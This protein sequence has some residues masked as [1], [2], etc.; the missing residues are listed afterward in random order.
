MTCR[1]EDCNAC[2]ECRAELGRVVAQDAELLRTRA[3]MAELQMVLAEVQKALDASEA[4]L[5]RYRGLYEKSRPNCSEHVSREEQQLVFESLLAAAN[6]TSKDG[7]SGANSASTSDEPASSGVTGAPTGSGASPPAPGGNGRPKGKGRP[8]GRRRLDLTHLPVDSVVFD[9]EE[10]RAAGGIGYT[11]VGSERS[12]RLAFVASRYVRL[13]IVR[14]TYRRDEPTSDDTGPE[15]TSQLPKSDDRAEQ[16]DSDEPVPDATLVTAPIPD[17]VWPNIMA[18]PST[19]AHT[20][21]AKYDD[22][23]PLNR[24]EGISHREGFTIHRS[25]LCGWL[26]SAHQVVTGIVDSM[27]VEGKATAHCMATDAT[28]ASVRPK[29]KGPCENWHIFV[30]IADQDHVVFR[31]AR[32]HDSNVLKGMLLGY[33]G[34]LLGDATSIYSPLI[35]VGMVVVAYCWAH[36]RRYF[37]RAIE[38]DRTRAH[39]AIAIIGQLFAVQR[40]CA[41]I[42]MPERTEQR[43]KLAE[44]ILQ[45]FDAWVDKHRDAVDPRSPLEAA[46]T[47]AGN[48]KEGLR[49]FL[50]DGR[51][52]ID[53]NVCEGQLRHSVLGRN[54]WQYFENE[55]GLRWY[56]TFRSLIASCKLHGLCPERYLECVLRLAPHWPK[57]KLLELSPK[58]WM[59]TAS[60]LSAAQR[61]IVRPPWSTAFDR[62]APPEVVAPTTNVVAA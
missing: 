27:F 42:P 32:T 25:T 54:N 51:L 1:A 55:N 23:L 19:I 46:I 12:S 47:Y 38:S 43:K 57:H 35:T 29:N 39:E 2:Q 8:H 11:L 26:G 9:P 36:L 48:Q 4:D 16:P 6:D 13:E 59:A 40:A 34:Y 52:R 17:A 62:F 10:V 53:N 41:N 61:A 21:V 37:F 33:K 18:D 22:L 31:H 49:R 7:A 30:F 44:P 58:H 50:D 60:K 28:G 20:I 5:N 45:L 24:Q 3:A 56:T 14:N 15:A